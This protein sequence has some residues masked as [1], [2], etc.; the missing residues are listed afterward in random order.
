ME[1]TL[2]FLRRMHVRSGLLAHPWRSVWT[3]AQVGQLPRVCRGCLLGTPGSSRLTEIQLH[4]P[5]FHPHIRA[6]Y[7]LTLSNSSLIRTGTYIRKWN[8]VVGKNQTKP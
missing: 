7:F 3:G 4:E 6:C 8:W 2:S 1:K 5:S